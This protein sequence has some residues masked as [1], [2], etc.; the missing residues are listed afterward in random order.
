M[1]TRSSLRILVCALALTIPTLL[2]SMSSPK[3]QVV[4]TS[5]LPSAKADA[6]Y[7]QIML[8]AGGT[9]PFTWSVVSGSLPS[10][11]RLQAENL[12]GIPSIPGTYTFTLQVSDS[13]AHTASKVF[14][15]TVK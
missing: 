10:G 15:L 2:L 12:V 9:H 1:N 8:S 11:I 13:K 4:S 6:N 14:S 7:A 3:L 5:P